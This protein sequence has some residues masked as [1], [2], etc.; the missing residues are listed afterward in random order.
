MSKETFTMRR[1]RDCKHSVV[2]ETYPRRDDEPIQS[3]YLMRAF[4]DPMP[5]EIRVT[6]EEK[7]Q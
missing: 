5:K 6:I 4:S 7:E 3:L 2:Y 1:K